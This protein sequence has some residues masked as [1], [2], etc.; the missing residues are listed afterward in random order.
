MV[1]IDY[2]EFLIAADDLE[3]RGAPP[4]V[5]AY[6]RRAEAVYALETG[7]RRLLDDLPPPSWLTTLLLDVAVDAEDHPENWPDPGA[8]GEAL[9]A[10]RSF[11]R[12]LTRWGD[13]LIQG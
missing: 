7:A 13:L 6:L 11:D 10:A 4:H 3:E 5:V 2:A 12:H 1:K 8:V 9:A